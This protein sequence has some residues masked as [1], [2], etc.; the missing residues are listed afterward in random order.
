MEFL[1]DELGDCENLQFLDLG[2]NLFSRSLP[3]G[4]LSLRNLEYLA[5]DENSFTVGLVP[6]ILGLPNLKYF[7]ISHNKLSG[8][9]PVIASCDGGSGN[10]CICKQFNRQYSC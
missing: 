4:F 2:S 3:S 7:D 8:E 6:D 5:V 10:L 9:I 1:L